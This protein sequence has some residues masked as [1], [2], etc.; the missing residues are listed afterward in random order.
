MN[1]NASPEVL[2]L[3][4]QVQ[5]MQALTQ[6]QIQQNHQAIQM[7]KARQTI[8]AKVAELQSQ[9]LVSSEISAKAYEFAKSGTD[10]SVQMACA[11]L[12]SVSQFHKAQKPDSHPVQFQ[13][14]LAQKEIKEDP[15]IMQAQQKDPV[16]VQRAHEI[17]QKNIEEGGSVFQQSFATPESFV[18]M[19]IRNPE[20]AQKYYS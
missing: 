11:F 19:V 3:Q 10:E 14:F 1:Q 2:Q 5:E 20:I 15:V 6:K 12:D 13:S 9:G 8:D 18:R 7:Q 4:K 16:L 17:Y